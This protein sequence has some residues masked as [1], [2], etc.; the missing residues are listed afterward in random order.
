[1]RDALNM[2][3]RVPVLGRA[4]VARTFTSDFNLPDYADL[5]VMVETAL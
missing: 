2:L 3:V 5:D 4:V 1:M